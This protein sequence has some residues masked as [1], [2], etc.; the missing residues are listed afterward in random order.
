MTMRIAAAAFSLLMLATPLAAE[1]PAKADDKKGT[2][3]TTTA[4]PS[5]ATGGKLTDYSVQTSA[6]Y[7]SRG[8]TEIYGKVAVGGNARG[9]ADRLGTRLT[10]DDANAPAL[11]I[12]GDMNYGNSILSYGDVVYAGANGS[13]KYNPIGTPNG[14]I[15]QGKGVAF[16]TMAKASATLSSML[17]AM[18]PTGQFTSQWG[19]GTLTATSAGLNIFSMTG[20]EFNKLYVLN[21]VG[22]PGDAAIVNIFGSINDHINF[23]LGNF[24]TESVLFNFVDAT[25]VQS[26]GIIW[27][28]SIL[29]PNALVSLEGGMV[30]GSIVS[31]AFN[32]AGATVQGYAFNRVPSAVPTPVPEPATWIMMIVGF[33]MVGG[34][35][36]RRRRSVTS[37]TA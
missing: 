31:R 4:A 24:A 37:V 2:T 16:D 1:K 14:S 5:T 6:D 34:F 8:S 13:P 10:K 36:R 35:V 12:G 23:N 18:K 22:K 25:D 21:F 3:T 15:Y 33:L 32:S 7:R 19:A 11:I 20:D 17:G 29:A 9:N 30:K 27:Q 26:N 28:G